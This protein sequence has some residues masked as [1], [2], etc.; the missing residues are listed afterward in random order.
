MKNLSDW[1]MNGGSEA[2]RGDKACLN[3]T[4][5][6]KWVRHKMRGW[7]I[8]KFGEASRMRQ[9]LLHKIEEL[10]LKCDHRELSKEELSQ[11]NDL[12][13]QYAE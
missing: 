9:E 4:N 1:L 6:L 8:Q 5:K 13:S 2:P 10:D 3:L 7:S 12:K 11:W